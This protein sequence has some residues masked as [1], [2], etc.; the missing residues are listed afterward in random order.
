M[1]VALA[2]VLGDGLELAVDGVAPPQAVASSA[3]SATALV[4]KSFDCMHPD[5][6]RGYECERQFTHLS[7]ALSHQRRGGC[8]S[9]VTYAAL[10]PPSTRNVA[11]LTKRESSPARN[12]EEL[13]ISRAF[14]RRPIGRCTRRRS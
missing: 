13:A 1:V 12:S 9:G 5:T 8:Y 4:I 14:A 10:S 7:A 2:A 3:A 6:E 11:P